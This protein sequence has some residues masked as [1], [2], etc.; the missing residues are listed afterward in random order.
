MH[1]ANWKY[2]FVLPIEPSAFK[3]LFGGGKYICIHL[4]DPGFFVVLLRLSLR[5]D[6]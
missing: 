3:F 6:V 2:L 4:K 1:M 5:F